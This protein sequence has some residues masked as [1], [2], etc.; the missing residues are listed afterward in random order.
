MAAYVEIK[1]NIE[2]EQVNEARDRLNLRPAGAEAFIVRFAEYRQG[3]AGTRGLPLLAAGTILRLREGS[4]RGDS[5]VKVR[6]PEGVGRLDDLPEP[7]DKG[8]HQFRVEGDWTGPS[9]Q[10]SASA[11]TTFPQGLP[12]GVDSS[13]ELAFSPAQVR[14]LRRANQVPID[15]RAVDV[16]TPIQARK[17][18][19]VTLCHREV[20]AE[21]WTVDELCFLEL[22]I[23]VKRHRA[24]EAQ[25]RLILD[26]LATG[27][28]L[29]T[30]TEAKTTR[31]LRHLAAR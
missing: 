30:S 5:T 2:G 25:A 11:V 24:V 4:G 21:Q 10:L 20:V 16:L 29:S 8:E 26:C 12:A 22:S 28:D 18:S 7:D 1:V 19:E 13:P 31:V 17:W 15:L 14:F 6:R 23:R 3:L 9:R 27:L